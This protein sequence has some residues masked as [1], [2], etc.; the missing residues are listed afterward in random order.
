VRKAPRARELWPFILNRFLYM[1]QSK[2][3]QS[4]G[5]QAGEEMLVAIESAKKVGA[6]VELID[7]DINL[8]MQR[9]IGRMGV[10]EKLRLSIEMLFG[11]LPFGRRVE[12]EKL[13]EEEF[14]EQLVSSLKR[15]LPGAY[16]VLIDERNS[17]M[18][19]KIAMLM[20][21]TKGKIVCVVGAGHVSGLSSRLD[22]RWR[23][24]LEYP[25]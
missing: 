9:L 10:M 25:L 18:A 12:L 7:R 1:L 17:Y 4:T 13:T 5:M 19:A 3:A 23:V 15:A 22:R 2:F 14:A 11:L 8:T 6:K 24:E 21:S 20:D 16:D